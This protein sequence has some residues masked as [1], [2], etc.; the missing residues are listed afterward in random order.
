MPVSRRYIYGRDAEMTATIW[1][2][3]NSFL[4][5]RRRELRAECPEM[6]SDDMEAMLVMDS[7][8]WFREVQQYQRGA[9]VPVGVIRSFVAILGRDEGRRAFRYVG[10]VD[11]FMRWTA[12][13]ND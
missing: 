1:Q 11:D 9:T 7:E 4:A 5:E 13:I 8:R 2:P 10:N 12:A 3:L 6:D